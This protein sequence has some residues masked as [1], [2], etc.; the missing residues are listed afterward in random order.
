[1][2]ETPR[3]NEEPNVTASVGKT[4]NFVSKH[5]VGLLI[6]L[7]TGGCILAFGPLLL[8]LCGWIGDIDSMLRLHILY[9]TGGIIAV[10]GLIETHRKNTTDRIKADAD[11]QNYQASQDHQ[12][13][14]LNEQAR[15]F[16]ETI[17]KEREKNRSR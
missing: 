12:A 1:M 3:Y 11:I 4:E 14:T 7:T 10:L 9:V 15:Q 13:K 5:F 2:T 17:A 6:G 16:T 8:H